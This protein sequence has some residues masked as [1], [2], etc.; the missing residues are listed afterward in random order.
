MN[1]EIFKKYRRLI[2]QC[3]IPIFVKDDF[4]TETLL[5][6]CRLAGVNVIEYT[7]RRSDAREA[8]PTLRTAIPD[9]VVLMGSI[10]DSEMVVN[11][12]K[13]KF[14]QLMT[15]AELAPYVD[16][17]VSMLPFCENTLKKYGRTHICI[18]VAETCGEALR[19]ISSG[20][21]FI[22][23][24]GPDLTL[25]KRMHATPTFNFCQTIFL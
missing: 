12:R 23:L 24:L 18:A 7:L 16:G 3:W 2:E 4:D 25:S 11:E 1:A 10:I 17:F 9:A 20:A 5:E 15:I 22:K 13:R 14:P 21:S 6:G 19:Q 8:L